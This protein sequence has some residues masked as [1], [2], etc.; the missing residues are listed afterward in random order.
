MKIL[1]E[2]IGIWW[3]NVVLCSP[4]FRILKRVLYFLLKAFQFTLD[5]LHA[6]IAGLIINNVFD[7]LATTEEIDLSVFDSFLGDNKDYIIGFII[8]SIVLLIISKIKRK[9]NKL[10]DR[11]VLLNLTLRWLY[12]DLGFDKFDDRKKRRYDLR[13]TI[14]SPIRSS[15]DYKNMVIEQVA[16]YCPNLSNSPSIHGNKVYKSN[17]RR[18][19]IGRTDKLDGFI[20]IGLVGKTVMLAL[21]N[22]QPKPQFLSLEKNADFIKEMVDVWHFLPYE[23]KKLTT[24]RRSYYCYPI[25]PQTRDDILALLYIDSKQPNA[26]KIKAGRETILEQEVIDR[27]II[28]I[29]KLVEKDHNLI[30]SSSESE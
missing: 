24:D 5:A 26:F 25:M 3:S 10:R 23:A 29:A 21:N 17:G 7:E 2:L 14:W 18:R 15:N 20:P 19:K 1:P 22:K 27:Y 6:V 11:L 16:D 9:R 13:C 4:I 8:L 28:R 12:E 30:L